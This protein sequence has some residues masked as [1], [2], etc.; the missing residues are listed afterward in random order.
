M[1]EQQTYNEAFYYPEKKAVKLDSDLFRALAAGDKNAYKQIETWDKQHHN[2]SLAKR[3]W[4]EVY[5]A[6]KKEKPMKWKRNDRM[7]VC[8]RDIEKVNY[9]TGHRILYASE[10]DYVEYRGHIYKD[11]PNSW[12]QRKRRHQWYNPRTGK[13]FSTPH[14]RTG[15]AQDFVKCENLPKSP[16]FV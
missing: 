16:S 6:S 5:A 7:R 10:G 3:Y 12:N 15:R 9:A 13:E 14:L 11:G 2:Q 1:T 4:R 8:C